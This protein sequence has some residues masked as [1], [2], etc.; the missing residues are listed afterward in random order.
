[1]LGLVTLASIL[2]PVL[3]V[4]HALGCSLSLVIR[5][6]ARAGAWL[7]TRNYYV[8]G[9]DLLNCGKK[10]RLMM[11]CLWEAS[12]M[13]KV[14]TL[15]RPPALADLNCARVSGTGQYKTAPGALRNIAHVYSLSRQMI[16]LP[17]RPR[18]L[19]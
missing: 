18:K 3:T 2:A 5:P 19:R 15:S 17:L 6:R 16:A 4:A 1:V 8:T 13:Y 11:A 10:H 12:P 9:G 7:Q 14:R